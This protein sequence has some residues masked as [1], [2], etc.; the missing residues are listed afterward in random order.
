MQDQVIRG[1]SWL[2]SVQG[3]RRVSMLG[4]PLTAGP[5]LPSPGLHPLT[6]WSSSLPSYRP[7]FPLKAS[8]LLYLLD[9]L[10]FL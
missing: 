6:V 4:G 5:P 9:N 1:G 8:S 7:G 2:P 10:T 3:P